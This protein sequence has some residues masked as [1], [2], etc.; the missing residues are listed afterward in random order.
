[1]HPPR[2]SVEGSDLRAELGISSRTLVCP[3]LSVLLR[4]CL[5]F[6][7]LRIYHVPDSMPS[8]LNALFPLMHIISH[9]TSTVVPALQVNKP[10]RREVK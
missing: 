4:P 7:F 2:A 1:M 3:L 5:F 6:L 10:R 9:Q 8:L